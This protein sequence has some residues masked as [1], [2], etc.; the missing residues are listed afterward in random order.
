MWVCSMYV[1]SAV[2]ISA[3]VECFGVCCVQKFYMD[4]RK[5][6]GEADS[7]PITTRQLESLVRLT[8]VR[9]RG[10]GRGERELSVCD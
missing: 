7:T 8:E 10:R 3:V 6:R 4:L 5:K 1:C 9:G 2:Y